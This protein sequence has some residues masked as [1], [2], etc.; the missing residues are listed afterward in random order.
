M[1]HNLKSHSVLCK[2]KLK[3]HAWYHKNSD[4]TTQP[5]AQLKPLVIE[6]KRFYDLHGNVWE[7]GW[8]SYD[9]QLKGGP[10]PVE[11]TNGTSRVMRGGSWSENLFSLASVLYIV[12]LITLTMWASALCELPAILNGF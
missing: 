12:L 3:D 1:S 9:A 8:D 2:A 6:G 7:W 11:S 5:V 4:G 10:N